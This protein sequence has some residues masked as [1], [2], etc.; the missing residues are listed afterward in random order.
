MVVVVVIVVMVL[1]VMVVVMAVMVV[2]VM[3]VMVVVRPTGRMCR[4]TELAWWGGSQ[5]SWANNLLD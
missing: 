5:P 4:L 1:V 2:V 3:V